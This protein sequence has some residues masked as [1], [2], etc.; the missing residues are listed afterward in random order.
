MLAPR[1]FS[2]DWPI[3]DNPFDLLLLI[4]S[5]LGLVYITLAYF[6]ILYFLFVV[7]LIFVV[8][9]C[10]FDICLIVYGSFMQKLCAYLEFIVGRNSNGAV[11]RDD[12][13]VKVASQPVC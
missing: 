7:C 5:P 6:V 8:A 9:V 2:S 10:L 1:S 3:S 13:I 11:C 12:N 4:T